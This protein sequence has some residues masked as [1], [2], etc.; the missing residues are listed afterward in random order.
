MS[1][2]APE[3]PKKSRW[4]RWAYGLAGIAAVIGGLAQAAGAI[5]LPGCANSDIVQTVRELVKQTADLTVTL[6]DEKLVSEAEG[7]RTCSAL[8]TTADGSETATLRYRVY[9]DGWSK[10]VQILGTGDPA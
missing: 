3:N 5:T 10:M 9:W 1:S 4:T 8:L 2:D 6:S 7:E